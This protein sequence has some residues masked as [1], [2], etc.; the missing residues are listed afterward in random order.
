[1]DEKGDGIFIPFVRDNLIHRRDPSLF[2]EYIL[3]RDKRA[4]R[5][6]KRSGR[7]LFIQNVANIDKCNKA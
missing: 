3:Y 5:G 7:R 4:G 6:I 2:K 1:M